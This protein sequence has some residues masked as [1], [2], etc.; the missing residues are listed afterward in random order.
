MALSN[1]EER[2]KRTL[3][4][5]RLQVVRNFEDSKA[6]VCDSLA[7]D[8]NQPY[9]IEVKTKEEDLSFLAQLNATGQAKQPLPL[10]RTNTMS[11][12][13]RKAIDQLNAREAAKESFKLIYFALYKTTDENVTYKQLRSTLYG[14]QDI[15]VFKTKDEF[16]LTECFYLTH[17]DFRRFQDLDAVVVEMPN[18]L[19]LWPNP[20]S[21]RADEFARSA[22]YQSFKRGNAVFDPVELEK[23]GQCFIPDF[24]I[25]RKD[26]AALIDNV[27]TKYNLPNARIIPF[28]QNRG[29][30]KV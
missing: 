22:L 28:S 23:N 10:S 2:A 13:I 6:K 18:G 27:K 12:I 21:P 4:A 24:N 9:L 8:G 19:E 16:E 26:Q 30:I 20:F 29:H 1:E 15:T 7:T 5:L 11:G 14:I 3:E 25:D 17:T